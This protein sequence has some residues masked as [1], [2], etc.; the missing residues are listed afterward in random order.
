MKKIRKKIIIIAGLIVLAIAVFLIFDNLRNNRMDL[1]IESK[2]KTNKSGFSLKNDNKIRIFLAG[3]ASPQAFVKSNQSCTV[4][5]VQGKAFVFDAGENA[6]H[7]IE[8]CGIPLSAVSNVFITHWHSDHFSGLDGLINNSWINGRE[9]LFN[10]YGPDGVDEILKG[11]AMAYRLDVQY[12]NKHFINNSE[13]AFAIPHKITILDAGKSSIV[14][15]NGGILIEAFKVDH[16]PVEHA[17]GYLFTYKNKKIFISGD[18]KATEWYFPALKNADVV[19][20]EAVY[21]G[22]VRRAASI[23]RKIG[24]KDDAIKAEKILE[25]HADTLELANL[26]ERAGVKRLVLTHMIPE[27]DG[28]IDRIMFV[29]GIKGIYHGEVSI[30]YDSMAITMT[31]D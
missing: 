9:D 8:G 25:Y 31:A 23:M 26:V 28:V 17:V 5:T 24:W 12:R 7:A 27:P 4:I 18:T 21:G 1:Y 29:H 16:R 3:T 30:G 20:H 2:L 6:M 14:Y 19:I 10:V 11:F 13:L 22:L 15:N